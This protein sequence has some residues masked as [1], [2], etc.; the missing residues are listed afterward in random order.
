MTDRVLGMSSFHCSREP[1]AAI[2]FIFIFSVTSVRFTPIR[3][4]S[5]ST[6]ISRL[7]WNKLL[8]FLALA[9]AASPTPIV[10]L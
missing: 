7:F 4:E 9:P 3:M 10:P 1:T 2:R 5:P 6:R 8:K